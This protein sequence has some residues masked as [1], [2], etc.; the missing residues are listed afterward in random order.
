[1]KKRKIELPFDN[2]IKKFTNFQSKREIFIE[3]IIATKS[4]REVTAR[5]GNN[6]N[7]FFTNQSRYTDRQ[8]SLLMS[9]SLLHT[10]LIMD[11]Y[12]ENDNHVTLERKVCVTVETPAIPIWEV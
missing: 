6:Y 2:E 4:S 8:T 3:L 10:S 11:Y 9:K 7:A 5:F 1:M 12:F